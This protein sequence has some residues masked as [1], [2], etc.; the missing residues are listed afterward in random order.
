M[1]ERETETE[2]GRETRRRGRGRRG[3]GGGEID[4]SPWEILSPFSKNVAETTEKVKYRNLR[5]RGER[6][7]ILMGYFLACFHG[8]KERKYG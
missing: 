2:T 8:D 1:R 7:S 6:R 5:Q 4:R 3:G